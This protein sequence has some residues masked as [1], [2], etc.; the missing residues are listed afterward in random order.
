MRTTGQIISQTVENL[1]ADAVR[2]DREALADSSFRRVYTA[3]LNELADVLD[4][5][6]PYMPRKIKAGTWSAQDIDR[7]ALHFKVLPVD[8]VPGPDDDWGPSD[9]TPVTAASKDAARERENPENATPD[10]E[11]K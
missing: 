1:L 6:R 5:S 3:K 8:L 7:I 10:R 2:E 9:E 4:V 11:E